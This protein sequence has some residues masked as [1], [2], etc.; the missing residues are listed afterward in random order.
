[1]I[2]PGALPR[3]LVGLRQ[4]LG[5]AW[6][7]L[8]VAENINADSGLGYLINHAREFLR[9]DVIVVGLAVYSLLGLA[10]TP[11]SALVERKAL[12]MAVLTVA[13]A[14]THAA[15]GDRRGCFRGHTLLRRPPA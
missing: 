1:M 4:S 13:R 5:I 6:L 2:V 8:I 7:A 9:T 14:A 12:R 11:S 10:P 15:G 3:A